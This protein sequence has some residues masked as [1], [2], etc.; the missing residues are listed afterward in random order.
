MTNNRDRRSFDLAASGDAQSQ[1][2]TVA[3]RLQELID[4]R[5]VQVRAAMSEYVATGV[6]EEYAAKEQRWHDVADQVRRIVSVLQGTLTSGDATA[7]QS[8]RG[9]G[10]AVAM[11]G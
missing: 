5:D 3:T 1:F 9:A 7:Q 4:Q 11:I 6:S 2:N 8:L 10:Q